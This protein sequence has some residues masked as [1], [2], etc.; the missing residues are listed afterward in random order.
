MGACAAHRAQAF[1]HVYVGDYG[2][3]FSFVPISCWHSPEHIRY[4]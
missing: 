1:G 2:E 4:P 3:D